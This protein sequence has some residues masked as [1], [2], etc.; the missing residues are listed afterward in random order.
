MRESEFEILREKSK[1]VEERARMSFGCPQGERVEEEE[2]RKK[3]AAAMK[4]AV[5]KL[6]RKDASE[7]AIVLIV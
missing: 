5:Q 3:R 4:K 2:K 6:E 7:R 1:K